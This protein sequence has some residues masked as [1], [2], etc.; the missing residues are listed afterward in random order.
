[1]KKSLFVLGVAVAAL[2]SC[3]NEEV[4]EV[5]QNRA[6]SFN[7]FV[8]NN[9]KAQSEVT[10]GNIG[11]QFYVIGYYGDAATSMTTPVFT[12]EISTAEYF[13]Q[14]SKSYQFA[15]YSNGLEVIG[16]ENT[17]DDSK[18]KFEPSSTDAELTFTSYEAADAD[19]VAAISD[20][21]TTD[22]TP[23]SES[24]VSLSFKHLLSKVRFTISTEIGT[25]FTLKIDNIQFS[26]T[27]TATGV[28]DGINVAWTATG[29]D[30]VYSYGNVENLIG[31][32]DKTIALTN[33]VIPQSAVGEDA[34]ATVTFTA[35]LTG[36]GITAA[37]GITKEF[38]A[39]LTTPT[40]SENTWQPG[41]VYN[42]TT[43][44]TLKQ[45]DENLDKL[46]ITFDVEELP[47]WQTN[48][49]EIEDND[50]TVTTPG[51]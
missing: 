33:L 40:P 49:I 38:S 30:A 37:E 26:A 14:A 27:K 28:F 12:N 25:Q 19:L 11:S 36:D 1:M 48:D 9:T 44:L 16:T 7:S 32:T 8:N 43:T 6:I 41:Y 4:T 23:T 34:I 35:T 22:A 24:P 39:D 29:A 17:V 51:A 10:D 18:V 31:Q 3:T 13:W 21:V 5:A 15:A 46:K 47:A 45:F 50:M 2:A 42:Y 20:V